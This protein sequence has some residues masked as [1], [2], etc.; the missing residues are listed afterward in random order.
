MGKA[1]RA[2]NRELGW[3][4]PLDLT[5]WG[6]TLYETGD[7]MACHV[8]DEE[9]DNDRGTWDLPHR[10][11]SI[12]LQ[13]SD[14]DAYEGGD[15]RILVDEAADEWDVA[16]RGQGDLTAF[17]SSTPHEVTEVTA[18]ERWVALGWSYTNHH[19]RRLR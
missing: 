4:I 17:G 11:I 16:S 10:G 13:L 1:F 19:R 14:P 6:C 9:R 8:D 5:R 7:W 15:L 3:R 2:A 18:G 12:S